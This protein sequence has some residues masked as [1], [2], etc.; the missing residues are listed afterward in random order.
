MLVDQQLL[1]EL[2]KITSA[3]IEIYAENLDLVRFPNSDYQ[4]I[5]SQY[6]KAKYAAYPPDLVI[7]A[8]VGN[9]GIPGRLLPRIFRDTPII[10]A[11]LTEEQIRVGEF[12]PLVSGLAQRVNPRAS[13][14]LIRRLQPEVRRVVVINGTADIDRQ[15]LNQVKA[16][17]R[18]FEGSLEF[19]FWENRTMAEIREAVGS[20]PR[21]AVILFGR[22]FRDGA[23]QAFVSAEAAQSISQLANVPVYVM[24]DSSLG[25]GAVGGAIASIETFARR[26]GELARLVLTGSDIN[27][28]PFEIRTETVPM[29]DWRALQRWGI[30]ESRL[31]A[32]SIVRFRAESLW[33]EYRWYIAGAIVIILL[34][35][36]TIIDL[37]LQRRRLNRVRTV[38]QETQELTDLA[39]SAGELGLWSRD[40]SAGDIWANAVTRSLFGFAPSEPLRFEDILSRVHPDDRARILSESE[41]SAASGLPFH[42]EFRTL[43]PDG[44]EHWVLAKGR[45]IADSSMD[46]S[47]RM[48]VMLDISERKR[49]EENLRES[50]DRFRTMANAAPVMIWMAGVDKL[51]NFFNK[52]WLDFTGRTLEQELGDGWAEGVHQEDLT[53]CLDIYRQAFDARQEFTMEY[54]LRRRDGDYRWVLDRGVPRSSMTGAFL[55]YIGTALDITERKRAQ[56]ALD[57]ERRFLRQV[58]DTAPNFIFAKDREGRFTLANRAV[59]EAYGTTVEHLVGKKDEDFNPNR[60]EVAFFER[61]DRAVIETRQERFIAEERIT[62]ARGNVRWVQTVKRPIVEADG[63]VRQVLGASTDITRRKQAEAQLQHQRAELAHVGRVSVMGE[64]SASLAH[65]LNQPLTA[66]RSNAQA[67]IHFLADN[68]PQLEEVKLILQ[69]IIRDNGRASEVIR[70]MRAMVKKEELDFTSIDIATLIRDVVMLVHSDAVIRSVRVFI[71]IAESL[72]PILGDRVQ[73]QQVLLNILLNAFDAMQEYGPHDREVRLKAYREGSRWIQV[74]VADK[75]PGLSA[76]KLEKIFQ[77]FFTTKGEGLGMGLSICRSIMEAHGGRLWAENNPDRGG[78]FYF[79]VPVAKSAEASGDGEKPQA[80]EPSELLA[81]SQKKFGT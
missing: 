28:L 66:I 58:I 55:G 64:L 7:L 57:K 52:G 40:L 33:Q 31:P 65:E 25:T 8:F 50:E 70:R 19:D 67:G 62:D 47:R 56:E 16:A 54:R 23:G 12:G 41:N 30:P 80:S 11:G 78:T 37:L 69:D 14:Q 20:L 18:E 2:G 29:F 73:L 26:A 32:G 63:S 1:R 5:F 21:D 3:R 4:Q 42:G 27:S 13:L 43:L 81:R 38:L 34:Q 39:T 72:P 6:L 68:P 22:F 74:A 59:A 75:G 71:D 61:I 35:A 60:E 15:F 10:V 36:L 77:P 17:A 9:L 53:R 45:T 76:D 51:C 24:A 79:T 44:T 48:G 46:G 49:A